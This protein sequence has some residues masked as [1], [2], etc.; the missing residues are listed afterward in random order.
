[1]DGFP[2]IRKGVRRAGDGIANFYKGVRSVTD[3]IATIYKGI[4]S[5]NLSLTVKFHHIVPKV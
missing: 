3:G 2:K 4:Q 5:Q 1:M